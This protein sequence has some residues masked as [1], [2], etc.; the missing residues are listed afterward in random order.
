MP[1]RAPAIIMTGVMRSSSTRR[2]WRTAFAPPE[3][4]PS[5]R[6]CDHPGCRREAEHRAPRSRQQL[7]EYYWFC[8]DHV[9][10]YNAAWD[11]YAGMKPEEIEAETRKDT[12]W[13][14]PTWPLGM[15]MGKRRFSFT[16]HDPFDVMDHETDEPRRKPRVPAT[17]EEEAMMVLG[18][19]GPLTHDILKAR[20]KELV[21]RHHPDAN[22]GD[23]EAEER[24]K[25][26]NQAYNTLKASLASG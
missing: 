16:I 24:F 8:L 25:R 13:Q 10:E 17:P 4:Q 15:Q 21:K 20:Y 22:N 9:R 19:A 23:K 7:D 18:L 2:S 12:T 14:R 1:W 5:T 6:I 26:I 11:Y 3:P